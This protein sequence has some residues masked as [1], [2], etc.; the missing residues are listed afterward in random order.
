MASFPK[1]WRW[2]MGRAFAIKA[3]AHQPR[4]ANLKALRNS[5]TDRIGQRRQDFVPDFG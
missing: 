2:A 4:G 1:L 3:P 5:I